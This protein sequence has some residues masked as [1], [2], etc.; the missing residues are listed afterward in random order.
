MNKFGFKL[1]LIFG[2]SSSVCPA[3][4]N[5]AIFEKMVGAGVV[6]DTAINVQFLQGQE[7]QRFTVDSDNDGKI[8]I[9]YLIDNDEKHLGKR[10]PLLVKIVDEDGDMYLTG[11]GDLDSDLYVADWYG[12]GTIDRVV[13]YLDKDGDNDVDE[14]YLFQWISEKYPYFTPK[15]Y[16]GKSY[17]VSWAGDYGD[18]NRL[19][20][21][22][23]YEYNQWLTEWLTD[24]NG[25]EMFV[26]TFYFDFEA[27]TFTPACEI[28]FSFYD[29]DSDS[30]SEEAVRFEGAKLVAENLRYSMDID[31]D[32]HAGNRH[33]YDFSITSLGPVTL[34]ESCCIR[35]D[36]R[37]I[38]TAPVFKWAEMRQFAKM[39]Q[40]GKTLLTWDENDNNI[41]PRPG[42]MHYERWEGV[43]NHG[44]EFMPQVG[45]PSC[46]PYNKR[47]EIDRDR[48]GEFRFY[49]SPVDR[50]FHLLGAEMGWI[51]VDYDYDDRL[52]MVILIEDTDQNGFFD[53]WKYDIDGDNDFE[54][55]CRVPCD[56]ATIYPFDYKTLHEAYLPV[57]K[58]TIDDN[59]LLITTLKA[60]LEKFGKKDAG[61]PVEN[62]FKTELINYDADY[63]LG[64]KVNNSSEGQKYYYDLIRERYWCSLHDVASVSENANFPQIREAYETGQFCKAARL[65][66]EYYLLG[67][68]G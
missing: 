52:D 21:H 17:C 41:D 48:S 1:M 4:T 66:N 20:Y 27:G 43:L 45:G 7:S 64:E 15:T 35:L 24:F 10:A 39:Q 32:A 68:I 58:K 38:K 51:K 19:W 50:R 44:S 18:D 46:G 34:P 29:L 37:G 16:G 31:N 55:I 57:L 25:D 59:R 14:Q 5:N 12:D 62:Y 56:T 30:L 11:E 54:R 36:I 42:S 8:D 6:M 26:C 23:N 2:L 33:D 13:D 28:A 22:T 61:D 40:W 53:T 60:V 65:L 63:R 49:Y 67:G 9:L 3:Q 47:N